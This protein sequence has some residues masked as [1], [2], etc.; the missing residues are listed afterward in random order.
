[1]GKIKKIGVGDVFAIKIEDSEYYYFGR[2]LFD[3]KEQ[4]DGKGQK[5][6]YLDWHGKSVLLETYKH[7]SQ[8]PTIDN[9]EIAVDSTFISKKRLFRENIE[10]IKNIP[11]N[12]KEITFPATFK[13]VHEEGILLAI[14]ELAL[15]TG[16][17]TGFTD[18]A[19]VFPSLGNTYYLQLATLDYSKRL[20]L[21]KDKK[22]IM[23]NYFKSSNLKSLPE[24][25]KEVCNDIDEDPNMSYY[26]LALKHGFDLARFY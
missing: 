7:I 21:I 1:M 10:V 26:E 22:D 18:K 8:K 5:N 6:N 25:Y 13:N 24:I 19:K 4:Y 16:F 15:L 3:V 17:S 23:D 9:F 11:V 20:D 2:I 12:P 14:G